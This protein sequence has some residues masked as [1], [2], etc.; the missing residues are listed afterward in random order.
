M[1]LYRDPAPSGTQ[2]D[3]ID[4]QCNWGPGASQGRIP[5]D[6]VLHHAHSQNSLVGVSRSEPYLSLNSNPRRDS[7]QVPFHV[8]PLLCL[9]ND[10]VYTEYN[11][12]HFIP[13]MRHIRLYAVQGYNLTNLVFFHW[14]DATMPSIGLWV[15]LVQGSLSA[16]SF[17]Q[18]HIL[19]GFFQR[20]T[21][22]F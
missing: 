21:L 7:F 4:Y 13:N 15:V 14:W 20:Q 1:Q 17:I 2:A 18:L 10:S 8:L 12:H 19:L 6:A 11:Y 16:T 5:Y 22:C 9:P 3:N